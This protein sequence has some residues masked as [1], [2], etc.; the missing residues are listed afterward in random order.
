MSSR[1]RTRPGVVDLT[2]VWEVCE[3]LHNPKA[4]YSQPVLYPSGTDLRTRM[5]TVRR[6]DWTDVGRT[7]SEGGLTGS[8]VVVGVNTDEELALVKND[9]I[10]R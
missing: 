8:E 7:G 2:V 9:V 3:S 5:P 4:L 1:C 6:L 10:W